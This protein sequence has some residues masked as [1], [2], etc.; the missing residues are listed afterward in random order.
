MR[1]KNEQKTK[2]VD[3]S[4]IVGRERERDESVRG[5]GNRSCL[6]KGVHLLGGL[7]SRAYVRGEKVQQES[8]S[9]RNVDDSTHDHQGF[10]ST[11]NRLLLSTANDNESRRE[12]ARARRVRS[13]DDPNGSGNLLV[14]NG[15][16]N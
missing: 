8:V 16:N 6:S 4:N 5:V 11:L 2:H 3:Y 9:K 10:S 1:C 12:R 14:D 7:V 13:S 15:N